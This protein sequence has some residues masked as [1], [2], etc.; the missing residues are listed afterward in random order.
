MATIKDGIKIGLGLI[1]L[2]WL[3]GLGGCA[4][5]I[6]AVVCVSAMSDETGRSTQASAPPSTRTARSTSSSGATF[7]RG[8]NLRRAP[9]KSAKKVGYVEP[10][11]HFEVL[12][13]KGAWRLVRLP[14]GREGWAACRLDR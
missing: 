6:G 13:M 5:F 7:R 8:C 10:G 11:G 9:K 2:K 12:R 4:A 3:L 1:L 14:D